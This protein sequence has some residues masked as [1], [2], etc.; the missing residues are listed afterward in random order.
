MLH[1]GDAALRVRPPRIAVASAKC[2]HLRCTVVVLGRRTATTPQ[3]ALE[4]WDRWVNSP[5]SG[6]LSNPRTAMGFP[7]CIISSGGQTVQVADAPGAIH[8]EQDHVKSGQLREKNHPVWAFIYAHRLKYAPLRAV[9]S[10]KTAS[11]P[12]CVRFGILQC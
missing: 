9:S 8:L 12:Q 7:R 3:D 5:R 6:I 1:R 4:T 10:G 11:F 2:T